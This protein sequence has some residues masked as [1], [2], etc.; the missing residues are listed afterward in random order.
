M[1]IHQRASPVKVDIDVENQP[2]VHYFPGARFFF[3]TS[4]P[5]VRAL[6]GFWDLPPKKRAVMEA[7]AQ[8]VMPPKRGGEQRCSFAR[9]LM[10]AAG[11]AGPESIF[12]DP[13]YKKVR[14]ELV[15]GAHQNSPKGQGPE[16]FAEPQAG[17]REGL[18]AFEH[19]RSGDCTAA[20]VPGNYTAINVCKEPFSGSCF[21][22]FVAK[23]Q[24]SPT[25]PRVTYQMQITGIMIQQ[26]M[27][28]SWAYGP[29]FW[30][31]AGLKLSNYTI[32][33][34]R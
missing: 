13:T 14:D 21:R 4:T 20:N 33:V 2:C 15:L 25:S 9:C 3:F 22:V 6:K 8:A 30:N 29:Q 19:K 7:L 26:L 11:E 24:L 31:G 27:G 34:W 16:G 32:S 23:R 17:E 18:S 1:F 28:I 12:L 10:E 5:S